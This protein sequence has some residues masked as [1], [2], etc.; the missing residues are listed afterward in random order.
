MVLRDIISSYEPYGQKNPRPTFWL[1][2]VKVVLVRT[3]GANESHLRLRLFK[4]GRNLDAVFFNYD[5]V[6][7]EGD[8]IDVLFILSKNNFR[9]TQSIQLLIQEII[10]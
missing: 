8:F 6:P 9:G 1:Y 2:G 10:Y 5:Y 7:K 3:I 4:A